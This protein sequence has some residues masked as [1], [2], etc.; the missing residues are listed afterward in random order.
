MIQ[1]SGDDETAG[2]QLE[3]D[4]VKNIS[5]EQSVKESSVSQ[6]QKIICDE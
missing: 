2:V 1:V 6:F 5:S 4:P 3:K